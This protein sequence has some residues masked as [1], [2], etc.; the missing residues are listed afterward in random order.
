[1]SNDLLLSSFANLSNELVKKWSEVA[2]ESEY[3]DKLDSELKNLLKIKALSLK[4]QLSKL[5]SAFN[6]ESLV[7]V[8]GAGV[9]EVPPIKRTI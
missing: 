5:I 6:D 9:S 2:F 3:F 7:L 1:M 4:T 8:L